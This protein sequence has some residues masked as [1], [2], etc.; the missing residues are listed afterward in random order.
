MA[1][2]PYI[3]RLRE[4]VGHEL[5]L[6]PS[7]AALVW[8]SEERLLLVRELQTER[9]QT[10]GGAVDPDESPQQAAVREAL[11]EAGIEIELT[12][13]RGAVGGPEFRTVYPNG[14]Q[15]AYVLTVF[16]ARISAG[17]PRPDNEETSAVEWFPISSL[18]TL[19]TT[20]FTRSLLKALDILT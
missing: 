2:A 5:L 6:V 14:D 8:D 12:G 9:W 10:I 4:H 18:E 1:I 19:K 15:V 13:I 7:A 16:D 20:P 3:R 11:E 17:T